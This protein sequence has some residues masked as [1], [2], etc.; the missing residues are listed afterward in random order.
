[1]RVILS[2]IG[3]FLKA[4]SIQENEW[5][6]EERESQW[7]L[8][9]RDWR[10]R[11]GDERDQNLEDKEDSEEIDQMRSNLTASQ[12]FRMCWKGLFLTIT[13]RA[14]LKSQSNFS[15]FSY[16]SSTIPPKC[17]EQAWRPDRKRRTLSVSHLT[18]WDQLRK[19]KW[20]PFAFQSRNRWCN[21]LYV[22]I[23]PLA[24][25]DD[26]T[27]ADTWKKI[28]EI[29]IVWKEQ[30]QKRERLREMREGLDKKIS[31]L[32][33][34]DSLSISSVRASSHNNCIKVKY[35][36]FPQSDN[37]DFEKRYTSWELTPSVL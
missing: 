17:Q 37:H 21:E 28:I 19:Q 10:Q 31:S 24:N 4:S 12:N 36:S 35:C 29:S 8:W 15:N 22:H 14:F 16:L 9:L 20:E 2:K 5:T 25:R 3:L 32:P 27:E 26:Q 6:I 34:S 33:F 1:M 7:K 23:D 30:L 18:L 11:R 13:A